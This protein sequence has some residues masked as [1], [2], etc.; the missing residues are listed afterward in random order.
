MNKTKFED[1]LGKAVQAFWIGKLSD[2]DRLL[3]QLALDCNDE[4]W[5]IVDD[6]FGLIEDPDGYIIAEMPLDTPTSP[7]AV[8]S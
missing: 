8:I 3:D 6:T 7:F 1:L 5:Q 2:C 4:Q